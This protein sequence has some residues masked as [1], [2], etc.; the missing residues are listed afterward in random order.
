MRYLKSLFSYSGA[1]NYLM[2]IDLGGLV[3]LNEKVFPATVAKT[4]N[5][6][7]A[8]FSV[9]GF[10]SFVGLV[11]GYFLTWL[12]VNIQIHFESWEWGVIFA[13]SFMNEFFLEERWISTLVMFL[14]FFILWIWIRQSRMNDRLSAH[15]QDIQKKHLEMQEKHDYLVQRLDRL[16]EIILGRPVNSGTPDIPEEDPIDG[17]P[18]SGSE[19]ASGQ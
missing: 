13:E 9:A 8:V 12:S 16:Y 14:M 4:L 5:W 2:K 10:I 6:V 1:R 7:L 17:Q 15:Q 19:P 18:Q 3:E 11:I